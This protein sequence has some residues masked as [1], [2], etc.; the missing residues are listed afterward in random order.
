MKRYLLLGIAWIVFAIGAIGVVIPV[1][2]TTPF[3]LLAVFLFAKCSPRCHAWIC[4]TKLYKSYVVPFKKEG[5][6]TLAKKI[7]ALS[8]SLGALAFSAFMVQK[9]TVWVILSCCA[10]FLCYLVLVRIPTVPSSVAP[11]RMEAEAE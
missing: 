11:R 8:I 5:G 9:V 4:S 1:L 2:P 10:L 3:L 6:L 7:R